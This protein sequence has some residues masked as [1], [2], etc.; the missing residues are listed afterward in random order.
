MITE[1]PRNLAGATTTPVLGM[2]GLTARTQARLIWWS[3]TARLH[4]IDRVAVRPRTSHDHRYSRGAG[5]PGWHSDLRPRRAATHHGIATST[6][7]ACGL[8][9]RQRHTTCWTAASGPPVKSKDRDRGLG[10]EERIA[11]PQT[12]THWPIDPHRVR[13]SHDRTSQSNC[14]TDQC[15]LIVQETPASWFGRPCRL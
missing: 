15:H 12:R 10:R 2:D 9:H 13:D 7:M 8:L 3:I 14:V 1:L 6:T 4:G 11:T 5:L